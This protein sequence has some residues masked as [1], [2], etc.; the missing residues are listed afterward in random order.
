M[1][2]CT[3]RPSGGHR[4][5]LSTGFY[6]HSSVATILDSAHRASHGLVLK[7]LTR[8]GEERRT[9]VH[10]GRNKQ[11]INVNIVIVLS[12]SISITVTVAMK[13]I[14]VAP[15]CLPHIP[16]TSLLILKTLKS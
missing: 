7:L 12:I 9:D 16:G 11:F 6:S 13:P 8:L 1:S 10:S 2:L 15:R 14:S 5:D 4:I 3:K